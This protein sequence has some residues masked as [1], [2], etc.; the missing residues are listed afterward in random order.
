MG[1]GG[2][3]AY[4]TPAWSFDGSII[5]I[6]T[7]PPF[8][9]NPSHVLNEDGMKS[10]SVS[11]PGYGR[12]KGVSRIVY[13]TRPRVFGCVLTR[14]GK[15]SPQ[16][17]W[18]LEGQ[19]NDGQEPHDNS[20]RDLRQKMS[21]IAETCW[22]EVVWRKVEQQ[23]QLIQFPL[24]V[25]AR[26]RSSMVCRKQS[27]RW[28]IEESSRLII[29]RLKCEGCKGER[30]KSQTSGELGNRQFNRTVK[31]LDQRHKLNF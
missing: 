19:F 7:E 29:P 11:C 9:E 8:L 1:P 27:R 28:T 18:K 26:K 21:A 31:V 3:R 2:L 24:W 14:G 4:A 16:H 23:G 10:C 15:A 12:L 22:G 5:S 20:I 17:T 30:L 13:H 6:L 25:A